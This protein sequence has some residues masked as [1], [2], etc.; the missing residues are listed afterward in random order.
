MF[1]RQLAQWKKPGAKGSRAAT[2]GGQRPKY[3]YKTVD[4]LKKSG[5]RHLHKMVRWLS[6]SVVCFRC[7]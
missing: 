4:E 3:V 2:A 7:H 1:Q 5:Q 6:Y